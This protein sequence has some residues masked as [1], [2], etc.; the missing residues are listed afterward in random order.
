MFF[1][2]NVDVELVCEVLLGISVAAVT[3]TALLLSNKGARLTRQLNDALG[4]LAEALSEIRSRHDALLTQLPT[5]LNQQFAFENSSKELYRNYTQLWA[6]TLAR[7]VFAQDK[8]NEARR[9][10]REY[11]EQPWW[12]FSF[13]PL[14]EALATLS[15]GNYTLSAEQIPEK[16]RAALTPSL[17]KSEEQLSELPKNISNATLAALNA[18]NHLKVAFKANAEKLKN[19]RN[20]FEQGKDCILVRVNQLEADGLG[21][22]TYEANVVKL[23]ALI[24]DLE[25][26]YAV[27]PLQAQDKAE[28]HL[29][30]RLSRVATLLRK[31]V[32]SR[33]TLL[34]L[35]AKSEQIH[36][37]VNKLKQDRLLSALPELVQ[38]DSGYSFS[39]AGFVLQKPLDDIAHLLPTMQKNLAKRKL[40]N[41]ETTQRELKKLI[42]E[43]ERFVDAALADKEGSDQDLAFISNSSTV[44]DN[45]ADAEQLA[46]ISRDYGAQRWN[47]A[48]AATA[49]LR[50]QHNA[51]L[52]AREQVGKLAEPMEKL[53]QT[54]QANKNVLSVDLDKAFHLIALEVQSLHQQAQC[55]RAEWKELGARAQEIH[56]LLLSNKED[57][58]MTRAQAEVAAH[59]QV[60]TELAKLKEKFQFL[61]NNVSSWGG[62]EAGS[63]L[64]AALEDSVSLFSGAERIKQ[65]W[66]A[67]SERVAL[68]SATV[69]SARKLVDEAI[70]KH[71]RYSRSLAELE[72]QLQ[73]H[74]SESPFKRSFCGAHFGA[75]LYNSPT[76][77]ALDMAPLKLSLEKRDY[78]ALQR[79]FQPLREQFLADCLE[80]WWFCFQSMAFSNVPAARSYAAKYGY[81]SGGFQAWFDQQMQCE[82]FFAPAE[83]DNSESANGQFNCEA[84]F[85]DDDE[86]VS[87]DYQSGK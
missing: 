64:S 31:A 38:F 67:L 48:R 55:G 39:E 53:L 44:D 46:A 62:A 7:Y 50:N 42:D 36:A 47:A 26:A 29:R 28:T 54:F 20:D 18:V 52:E 76:A 4:P 6:N 41:V 61:Q 17:S 37:R 11:K 24:S 15:E 84:T 72:T 63:L 32:E 77:L 87:S 65:D 27:D 80:V 57:A 78:A 22:P 74:R 81:N 69:K 58:L 56:A 66:K 5:V 43:A 10:F 25:H 23:R 35:R 3:I 30:S 51:R 79:E 8:D 75:A 70:A 60:C 71:E 2:Y 16:F 82:E 9:L 85:V 21:H 59:E 34:E 19:F 73:K 12:K 40:R 1:G 13:R 83:T 68:T 33:N 86:P 14:Q 45:E 49:R